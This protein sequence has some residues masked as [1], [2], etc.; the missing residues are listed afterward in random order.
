MVS[1]P[2][3]KVYH[4]GTAQHNEILLRTQA[5]ASQAKIQLVKGRW[6]LE[7]LAPSVPIYL[8]DAILQ[9]PQELSKY[10]QIKIGT[11]RIHW[12][13]YYFEGDTQELI[14]QDFKS[15]HGRISRS[16]F[17]A[18][19]LLT[20]GLIICIFFTPGI[21]GTAYDYLINRNLAQGQLSSI[22]IIQLI[23]P[24]IYF[25]AYSLLGLLFILISVK[26]MRDAGR[27]VWQLFLPIYNL[28]VLY[29][30]RSKT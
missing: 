26:R 30:E 3:T 9:A 10:D 22:Q 4:I 7:N 20:I 8:N 27:P 19:S 25:L 6:I 29:F 5:Q 2:S 28:K 15:F 24:Y 14:A 18:L 11:Q 21:L 23:S 1:A 16:N 13:D 12:Q 17:R